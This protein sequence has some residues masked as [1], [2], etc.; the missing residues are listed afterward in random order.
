M[1]PDHSKRNQ[2]FLNVTGNGKVIPYKKDGRLDP[3]VFNAHY[4]GGWKQYEAD[5]EVSVNDFL[6]VLTN[7]TFRGRFLRK[8]LG[9]NLA[10]AQE[11]A[12]AK[13]SKP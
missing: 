8:M 6:S 13:R 12:A 10:K 7:R 3:A 11:I 4:E 2:N 9:V 5:A 1:K